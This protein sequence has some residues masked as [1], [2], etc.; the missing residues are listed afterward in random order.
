MRIYHHAGGYRLGDC[1]TLA[2]YLLC[3]SEEIGEPVGLSSTFDPRPGNDSATVAIDLLM[4][5]QAMFETSGS[6]V[7][8]D[9]HS[10]LVTHQDTIWNGDRRLPL[11]THLLWSRLH[12][13]DQ[14][15]VQVNG[16][17]RVMPEADM[18]RIYSLPNVVTLGL[19]LTLEASVEAMRTCR[20]LICTCSAM[21]HI[22]HASGIPMI[23]VDYPTDRGKHPPLHWFH[24]PEATGWRLAKGIDQALQ[25]VD[26]VLANHRLPIPTTG[27]T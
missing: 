15:A 13:T 25:M 4:R 12:A 9:E 18:E 20:L 11:K 21:S 10:D 22:G 23:L 1:W 17:S 27:R 6:F 3:R 24:P 26:F 2:N 14:I 8:V 5:I 7:I 16:N 19:P